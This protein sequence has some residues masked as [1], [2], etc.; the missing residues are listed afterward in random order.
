MIEAW[1]WHGQEM[2]PSPSETMIE[3]GPQVMP[4]SDSLPRN[5]DSLIET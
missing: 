4:P 3:S 1:A 2:H 5:Y